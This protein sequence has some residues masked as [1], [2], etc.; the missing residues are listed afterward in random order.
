LGKVTHV[1]STNLNIFDPLSLRKK[2]VFS[3]NEG[4]VDYRHSSTLKVRNTC[5]CSLPQR[6]VRWCSTVVPKVWVETQTKVAKGQ[7]M[8]RAE[9]GV[10]YFQRYHCLSVS[11]CSVHTWQKW[12]LLT[13]K[14]T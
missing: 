4:T 2:C 12:R 11:V 5:R 14:T 1:L 13:L 8:G 6:L 3:E 7:K 9:A 10:V